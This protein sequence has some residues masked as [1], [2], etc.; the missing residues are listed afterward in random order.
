MR[1]T[2]LAPARAAFGATTRASPAGLG[3]P[4]GS[5]EPPG[6]ICTNVLGFRALTRLSAGVASSARP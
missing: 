1:T 6:A 2:T 3:S 5:W 4:L